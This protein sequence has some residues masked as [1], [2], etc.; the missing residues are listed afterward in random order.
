MITEQTLEML[1]KEKER[2]YIEKGNST[3]PSSL[4]LNGEFNK[5]NWSAGDAIL[6]DFIY[7]LNEE[8]FNTISDVFY[9]SELLED[10]SEE[11]FEFPVFFMATHYIECDE[12]YT[13]INIH[14]DQSYVFKTYTIKW[15]KDRGRIDH[16]TFNGELI[17]EK[18]Y[19]KLLNFIQ[20][21]NIYDF[22]I[23]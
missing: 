8:C 9:Y 5:D 12:K 16:I 3:L 22:K 14:Q 6:R 18:E 20:D 23:R 17:T 13:V 15:Y 11:C 1:R 19:L 21:F 2:K 7:Y 4:F 10:N